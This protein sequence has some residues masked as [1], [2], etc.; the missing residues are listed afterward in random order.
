[1]PNLMMMMVMP[2]RNL[3]VVGIMVVVIMIMIMVFG[4]STLNGISC[5]FPPSPASPNSLAQGEFG[6]SGI[7]GCAGSGIVIIRCYYAGADINNN[8]L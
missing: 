7:S 5:S 8:L 1:M 4:E 3:V 6:L 2:L